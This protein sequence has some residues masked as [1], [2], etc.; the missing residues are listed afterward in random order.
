MKLSI[1]LT[2]VDVALIDQ[3]AS[4]G[5]FASRSAVVQHALSKLRAQELQG[6]YAVAWSEWADAGDA[7]AWDA[8]AGDGMAPRG[9]KP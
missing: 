4:E 6:S 7:D 2:D 1:S 9:H 8:A 3:F 5:G